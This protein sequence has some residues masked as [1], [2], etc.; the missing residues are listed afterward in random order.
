MKREI[1]VRS[2][3]RYIDSLDAVTFADTTRGRAA[4]GGLR[5]EGIGG[6]MSLGSDW[7]AMKKSGLPLNR[8][9][10]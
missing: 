3:L 6:R 10:F 5:L 1:C 2:L 4:I 7:K 8:D 9:K